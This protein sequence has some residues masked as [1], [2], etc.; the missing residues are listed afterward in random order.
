MT[1]PSPID[2]SPL[3]H[4]VRGD[5]IRVASVCAGDDEA[6]V[7]R[8]ALTGE[9]DRFLTCEDARLRR[10]DGRV[11][12]IVVRGRSLASLGVATEADILA[13]FGRPDGVRRSH[14][15][16]EYHYAARAFVVVWSG[17]DDQL[18]HVWLDPAPWVEPRHGAPT[19]LRELR[20]LYPT[21]SATGW[22]EPESPPARARFR[23][24]SALAHAFGLGPLAG[25]ANGSFVANALTPGRGH[26][27]DEIAAR[28]GGVT[29]RM[30]TTAIGAWVFR[31]LFHYRV[32]VDRVVN[33]THGVL[34]CGDAV[35]FGMI[36]TQ[37][38]IGR[39]I[40]GLMTDVD[41]WLCG[42]ID[43][44]GRSFE[45]RVLIADHGWP[46]VDLGELDRVESSGY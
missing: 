15:A 36:T 20:T 4:G 27:L 25:I 23:R 8:A 24:V 31:G 45:E 22:A 3:L 17:R 42:L 28:S 34:E 43:P 10:R 19:L 1:R 7:D 13:R 5:A 39:R 6:A 41:R 38:D 37:D 44:E 21:L 18:S 9:D 33:A 16:R 40:E 46:D 12:A 35:L 32:D 14:G 26:V 30:S 11:D 2:L 29:N